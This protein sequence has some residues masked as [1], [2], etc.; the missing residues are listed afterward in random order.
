MTVADDQ[1]RYALYHKAEKILLDDWGMA[2]T[3]MPASIA[4][5]KPNVRNV[6]LTPFGFSLFT[7]IEID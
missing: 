2:P 3:P 1:K 6:T 7:R 4:L 5:R